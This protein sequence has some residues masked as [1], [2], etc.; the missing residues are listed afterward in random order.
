[1]GV[2]AV[3]GK[4]RTGK[5][6]LINK[7]FINKAHAFEVGDTIHA[8]TKGLWLYNE[9]LPLKRGSETIPTLLMDTEG[10]GAL[11]EEKNHDTH[12]FLLSILLSSVFI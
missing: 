3:V 6:Y 5:S 11:D 4:Y 8:C 9:I 10:M 7:V 12:I 2:T 1:M